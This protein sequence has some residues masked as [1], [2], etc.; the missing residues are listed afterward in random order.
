MERGVRKKL[1][2]LFQKKSI[3]YQTFFVLVLLT[4]VTILFFGYTINSI[5][6]ERQRE[7]I[8]DLNLRQMRR[9]SDEVDL[10]CNL[11]AHDMV[12]SLWTADFR[13][14]MID[15]EGTDTSCQSRIVSTLKSHRDNN[16][17]IKDAFLFTS[18]SELVYSSSGTFLPLEY[19]NSAKV[20]HAYLERYTPGDTYLEAPWRVMVQGGSVYLFEEMHT[21]VFVGLMIMELDND[22]LLSIIQSSQEEQLDFS[23]FSEGGELIVGDPEADSGLLSWYQVHPDLVVSEEN[24]GY[25]GD[26]EYYLVQ[27]EQTGWSYLCQVDKEGMSASFRFT[28]RL[29]VPAILIYALFSIFFSFY[30]TKR[31]YQPISHLMKLMLPEGSKEPHK[32]NEVDFLELA[33]SD[34]ISRNEQYQDLMRNISQDVIRQQLREIL[35]GQSQG[36]E[37]I[38]ETFQGIG[39]PELLTGRYQVVALRLLPPEERKPNSIEM[40]LYQKSIIKLAKETDAGEI[41][42]FPVLVDRLT[43]ALVLWGSE[44]TAAVRTKQFLT[45]LKQV[46]DSQMKSLPFDLILGKGKMYT[47]IEGAAASYQEAL[48]DIQYQQYYA[49]GQEEEDGPAQGYDRYYLKEKVQVMLKLAFDGKRAEAEEASGLMLQEF[50]WQDREPG[51]LSTYCGL[52]MDEVMEWL[53]ESGVSEEDLNRLKSFQAKLGAGTAVS[54]DSCKEAMTAF[55]LDAIRLAG[56]SSRKNRYKYVEEAKSY[57][58]AHYM[59]S[60]LSLNE[61]SDYIGITASYLSSLFVE[62]TGQYFSSYLNGFRIEQAKLLLRTTGRTITEIGYKCGFNSVQ[63]FCRSFKKV[64]NVTPNGYRESQKEQGGAQ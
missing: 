32:G 47:G 39:A 50:L 6:G 19:S 21:P 24:P 56:S 18:F 12:Q 42:V 25:D 16:G 57:I 5:F 53:I 41:R 46:L 8:A 17:L 36:T 63:S 30:L 60:N 43:V 11:L 44:E 34:S 26:Q 4:G 45:R 1:I 2:G 58:S 59:D 52:V 22:G 20:I 49:G 54:V 13:K 15:P 23:V 51:Q 10:A 28:A 31:V 55:C 35:F 61:I 37:H 3:F 29:M 33:Y 14:A 48:D 64:E 9:I 7:Q 27:S 38:R 40:T 62:V